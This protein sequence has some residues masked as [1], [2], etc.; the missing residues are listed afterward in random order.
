M[1]I[2]VTIALAVMAVAMALIYCFYRLFRRGSL[3]SANVEAAVTGVGSL[4][5]S[6][7]SSSSNTTT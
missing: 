3:A 7:V 6:L 1:G 5:A 2:E 4:R